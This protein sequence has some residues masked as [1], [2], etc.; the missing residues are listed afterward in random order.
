MVY[1]SCYWK[2]SFHVSLILGVEGVA[3]VV[4]SSIHEAFWDFN[5]KHCGQM[6]AILSKTAWLCYTIDMNMHE[7]IVPSYACMFNC[8]ILFFSSHSE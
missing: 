4:I 5:V 8:I 6:Q 3:R 1:G 7:H 2:Y